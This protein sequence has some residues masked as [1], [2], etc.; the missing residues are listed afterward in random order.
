MD[1]L[2]VSA[3]QLNET[4]AMLKGILNSPDD[5]GTHVNR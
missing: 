2:N 4:H 1:A 3:V 5:Y